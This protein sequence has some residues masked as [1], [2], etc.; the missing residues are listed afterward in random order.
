LG[1]LVHLKANCDD[2]PTLDAECINQSVLNKVK[3]FRSVLVKSDAI[4]LIQ[5]FVDS[6]QNQS[7]GCLYL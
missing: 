5:H 4:H 3:E 1:C 7:V 2:R 6:H